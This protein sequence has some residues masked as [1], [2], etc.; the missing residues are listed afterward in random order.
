[1]CNEVFIYFQK[2]RIVICAKYLVTFTI[3]WWLTI[4]SEAEGNFKMSFR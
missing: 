4:L 1:M 2:A 3:S